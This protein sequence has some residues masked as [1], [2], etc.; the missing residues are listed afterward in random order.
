MTALTRCLP[1]SIPSPSQGV[2][3]LGPLP[4]RAYALAIILG[5]VA[6]VWTGERRWVARGGTPGQ[7]GDIALWAVPAGLVGARL[8]HVATDHD[9]YFGAGRRPARRA[10]DLARRPRH[11]GRDR[12]RPPRRLA[13]LPPPRHPGAPARRRAGPGLLL[14]QAIGR[15]GNYFNQEL[16]GRPTDAAVGPGDRRRPTAPRATSSSPPSTPRS[17]TRRC[18]TSPRSAAALA[19]PPLPARLRPGLRALRDGLHRRAA[20]GSRPAHRHRRAQRR[21]SACG[22][23]CGCRS[24]CS[25]WPRRTSWSSRCGRVARRRRPPGR[26][27]EPAAVRPQAETPSPEPEPSRSGAD[28]SGRSPPGD[29]APPATTAVRPGPR[30]ACSASHGRETDVVLAEQPSDTVLRPAGPA[31]G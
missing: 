12:R 19:R 15:F 9:L 10:G 14:A 26:R 18:G 16:F 23:A 17:S 1:L 21:R 31:V 8:Y 22:W 7:V 3:H 13:L 24:C 29:P 6:A 28:G 27:R 4:I 11:L 25:C 2:W 20:A 30:L 5:V